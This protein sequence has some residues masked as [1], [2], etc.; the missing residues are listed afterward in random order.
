MNVKKMNEWRLS[1]PE[2]KAICPHC[3]EIIPFDSIE[4]KWIKQP[5]TCMRMK[6]NCGNKFVNITVDIK[7]DF[8]AY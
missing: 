6:C 2:S 4:E 1:I 8:V 7:G 5:H 3:G